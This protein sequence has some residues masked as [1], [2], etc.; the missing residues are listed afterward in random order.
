VVVRRVPAYAR[1][2]EGGGFGCAAAPGGPAVAGLL[3]AALAGVRRRR[4]LSGP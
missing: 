4:R 3:A 2:K 1:A